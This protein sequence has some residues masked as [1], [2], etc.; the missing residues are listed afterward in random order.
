MR[1]QKL[2]KRRTRI[3]KRRK[4]AWMMFLIIAGAIVLIFAIAVGIGAYLRYKSQSYE[5]KQKY[6]FEGNIPPA[7]DGA[8]AVY[9]PIYNYEDTVYSYA[10]KGYTELSVML[11]S[12]Q[13]LNYTSDIAAAFAGVDM[14]QNKL[15]DYTSAMHRYEITACGYFY[16]SAFEY[17]DESMRL[18]RKSYEV[19]LLAEAAQKGIDDILIL[20]IN[21]NEQNCAEVARYLEDINSA[22]K[23]CSVGIAI[24]VGDLLL[25]NEEIYIAGA[26]KS[27]ADFVALDLGSLDFSDINAENDE[28]NPQNLAQYLNEIKYYL[29]SYSLRLVFSEKN[30]GFCKEAY[31]LGFTNTQAVK[32]KPTNEKQEE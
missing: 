22:A 26:M 30:Q 29:S 20:G 11:G 21:V 32:G 10:S 16:S 28:K 17:E 2:R 9:A 19:A 23:N 24:T 3:G 25:T 7:S 15:E 1:V 27:S 14:A 8:G 4:R 18:L 12:A 13:S 5:P 31:D 6:N